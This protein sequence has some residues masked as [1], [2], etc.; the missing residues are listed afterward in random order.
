[1]SA[2]LSGKTAIV[3]GASNGIGRAI[4]ERLGSEEACVYLIGRTVPP[5]EESAERIA[6]AGGTA[7]VVNLDV[8]DL[9]A[10]RS[11]IDRATDETGRL[12]I[13]VNNAALDYRG[14]IV[15]GDPEHWR[16]MLEVNVLAVLVGSQAAV[17]A[18]RRSGSGGHIV[19][20]S[21]VATQRRDS[22][23]YGATKY[24]VNC[25]DATLREELEDDDIRVITIMP[26][27][28]ATNFA[29]NFDPEVIKGIAAL[30]GVDLEW[31]KGDRLPDEVLEKTQAALERLIARP[32]DVADAVLYAVTAP[33]RLNIEEMV[34]RPAKSMQL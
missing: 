30:A 2:P 29:R 23:V 11:L 24:A 27:I 6:R 32:E 20:I 34:V 25:I 4:A 14:S 15:D 10:I 12:D 31:E 13:M 5:M 33:L 18:M 22:G 7:H 28:V 17:A 3:T 19:T 9:D 16:E 1:M 26:G 21:S 8:R